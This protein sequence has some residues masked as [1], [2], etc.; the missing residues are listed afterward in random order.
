M[1]FIKA[2][3]PFAGFDSFVDKENDMEMVNTM[4]SGL[5]VYIVSRLASNHTDQD[6]LIEKIRPWYPDRKIVFHPDYDESIM[7]RLPKEPDIGYVPRYDSLKDIPTQAPSV[8]KPFSGVIRK[9]KELWKAIR[10]LA[11]ELHDPKREQTKGRNGKPIKP[12]DR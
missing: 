9:L 11:D 1:P 10:A 5:V 7:P 3:S 4:P 2:I 8:D 6:M 12:W